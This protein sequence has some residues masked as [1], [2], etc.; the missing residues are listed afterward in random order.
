VL[1]QNLLLA[2]DLFPVGIVLT[3]RLPRPNAL[4]SGGESAHW[5]ESVQVLAFRP[6]TLSR[7][8]HACKLNLWPIE[9]PLLQ[10]K[11]KRE[12]RLLSA[13]LREFFCTPFF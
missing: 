3:G 6:K 4:G 2:I 12:V 11:L 1:H 10:K 7:V 8:L 9:N 13:F 5:D